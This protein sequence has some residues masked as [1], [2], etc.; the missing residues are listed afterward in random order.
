MVDRLP[1]GI[2][3]VVG[4]GNPGPQYRRTR[5]NVGFMVLD[6]LA[7]RHG[8]S[9]GRKFRR[10]VTGSWNSPAGTVI[11]AEPQTFMNASGESA[12]PIAHFYHLKPPQVLV[13]CD[14]VSLPFGRLRIRPQGSEGGHNGLKSV[15]KCLGTREY[16]RLRVGIGEPPG[17]QPMV[18]YVL[19]PFTRKEW[20]EL[21]DVL[22]RAADAIE[23]IVIDGVQASMNRF[24]GV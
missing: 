2:A 13:V 12:A 17:R 21:P 9:I 15:T 20:E 23:S 8:F 3:L 11:L 1:G 16:P 24:N 19:Q 4:L 14:D 22:D 6:R 10:A 18:D 5:H 7:E